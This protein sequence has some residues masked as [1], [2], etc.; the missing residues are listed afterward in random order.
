MLWQEIE[1]GL[2]GWNVLRRRRPSIPSER[3]LSSL[4]SAVRLLH[5]NRIDI[6]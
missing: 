5:L 4:L 2:W 3:V 1:M 6:V